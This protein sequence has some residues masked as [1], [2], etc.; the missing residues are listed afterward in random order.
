VPFEFF[1]H[2]GDIGVTLR[3]ASLPALFADAAAALTDVVS[4]RDA[5]ARRDTWPVA[6]RSSALDLLLVEFLS[7]LL[8]QFDARQ[9]LVGEAVVSVRG[10][11]ERW[12]AEGEL[13]GE[14]FDPARHRI[15]TLVKAVT[16][17]TLSVKED[18]DGWHATLV[19]DI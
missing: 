18:G 1:D 15:R 10:E 16:Y 12:T 8:F 2:T 11:G 5:V 14:R 4:E 7:E 17:H 19:L 9:R 6:V 3:A 13:H